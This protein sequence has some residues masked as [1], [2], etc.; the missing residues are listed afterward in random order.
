MRCTAYHTIIKHKMFDKTA[1]SKQSGATLVEVVISLT[2]L[3]IVVMSTFALFA[4]LVHS[5]LIAKN[6]AVATTLATNQMEYLKG[7]PYDSLA[8]A[9]GSIYSSNPLPASK[10]EKANGIT[11]TIKTS[12]NYVDDAYDGCGHYPNQAMKQ[13]YCRNYPPPAGAPAID[14]NPR[15]YKVINVKVTSAGGALLAEVDT[16]VGARVAETSSTTGALL[17]SVIDDNGNPVSS[18]T[19]KLNNNTV[20]PIV[21]LSDDTDSNGV[22]IFYGLPPD[23]GLDYIVSATKSGYSQLSTIASAGSLQPTYPNQKVITQQ[24]SSLTL[25]LKPQGS[26]SLIVEA[27]DTNGAPVRNLRVYAKGGYKKYTSPSDTSYYYDNMSPDNRP[28]TDNSGVT[29]ITDLVPGPYYFCGDNGSSNC[30]VGSTTYYLVAA[31]AY[32][33]TDSFSPTIIPRYEPTNPPTSLFNY[34]GT[35]YLQKVRLIVTTAPNFPRVT[36]LSPSEISLASTPLTD[37]NFQITGSNLPCHA[38]NPAA[39][40][41]TVRLTQG[42]N[43]YTA[44][45]IGTGS[46]QLDCTVNLTGI[47]AGSLQ[48]TIIANG[49]T[50]NS[51]AP[52]PLGGFNVTP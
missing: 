51:P 38:S 22:A 21:D 15:D 41:T 10:T 11:Y 34:N 28:T 37:F 1:L 9:G 36:S 45:C 14:S 35:D 32:D 43:T 23:N 20:S 5:T 30:R 47:T 44:S 31:L 17:V 25:T 27:V 42:G 49:S 8:V 4:S 13:L 50:F 46:K 19:V 40:N 26:S 52:P 2:V 12:I 7:L 6:K 39:C 33:G 18:A 16:Q 48:T 3:A 24:S 29:T